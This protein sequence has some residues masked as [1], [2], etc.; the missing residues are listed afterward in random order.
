[1]KPFRFL[2]TFLLVVAAVVLYAATPPAQADEPAPN[3][4]LTTL[5]FQYQMD[6]G[7]SGSGSYTLADNGTFV[8]DN[9]NTGIWAIE[10]FYDLYLIYYK[11]GANCGALSLGT[12]NAAANQVHGVRF[13]T[14]DSDARGLWAGV[15]W[16]NGVTNRVSVASDGAQGDDGSGIPAVSADGRYVA[17]YSYAGNLVSGDTNGKPDIFVH[18]RQT[19]QVSRISIASDGTEGNGPSWFSSIS[20]DGR[21]VAFESESSNLVAGDANGHDDIFVHD[22]QTGQTNRVSIASDGTEGNSYS[23]APDISDDGRYVAFHSLASNLVSDDTNGVPDVF[24]HDRQTGQTFRVSIASDGAQGNAASFAPSISAD[25][26]YVAFESWASNL[27]SDDTNGFTDVF[28]HHWPLGDTT[29]VSVATGGAQADWQSWNAAISGDGRYVAFES[30]ATNLVIGD[31]NGQEDVFVH[32]RQTG[33]GE[34]IR[35]S[36][37]SDGVEGN[38][39]SDNPVI[40]D[41]GRYVAFH[42]AATNLVNGDTNAEWDIFVHD[43][44]TEQTVR[45]SV[46]SNGTQGY[47]TSEDPAISANGQIVAFSS[48]S[49]ALVPGDTNLENDVFVRDRGQ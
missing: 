33:Q 6:D 49:G 43:T 46:A 41:D 24:V 42:S 3:L 37:A 27:V 17:F 12:Y 34:T 5:Y 48:Y 15:L 31:T 11:S 38:G 19:G 2:L 29:R 20:A 10:T 32:D 30:I 35:A 39:I 4:V 21:Y 22:R 47:R 13:C 1:M 14:D 8:D 45:V 44:L 16:F 9:G 18:D 28:V 26:Q 7:S 40:S 36:I 23:E 25:G